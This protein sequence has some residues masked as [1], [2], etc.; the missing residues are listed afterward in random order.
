MVA[1][2]IITSSTSTSTALGPAHRLAAEELA[3]AC[4]AELAWV[5]E[6]VEVGIVAT[7]AH[8]GRLEDWRFE[9]ADLQSALAARR[10]QRDFDV[11]LD[12]A[13]LILDLQ[14]ELRRMKALLASRGFDRDL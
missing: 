11:G 5:A 8:T 12:A 7:S 13:A 6:L 2:S 3:R 1:V 9:S 14:R 10:L 4:G